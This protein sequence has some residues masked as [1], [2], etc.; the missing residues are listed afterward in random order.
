M[1]FRQHRDTNGSKPTRYYSNKQ[2]TAVAKAIGGRKTANSGATAYSKGDVTTDKV[3]L[4]CK[5]KMTESKSIAIYK[6]WLD[7]LREESIFMK[8]PFYTLVFNF[9]ENTDNYYVIPESVYVQLLEKINNG[10]IE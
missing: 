10:E 6:E 1:E 5:T 3:L 4:E 8:K 7:K 2:E 9:G